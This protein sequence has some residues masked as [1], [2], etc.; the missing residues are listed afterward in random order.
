MGLQAGAGSGGTRSYAIVP[1]L[2]VASRGP[3]ASVALYSRKEPRDIR[4][5]ALD[6]THVYWI[7]EDASV[8]RVPRGLRI[9]EC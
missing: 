3:V 7:N 1:D 6:T 8:H 2:A 5:I 4:S 9:R